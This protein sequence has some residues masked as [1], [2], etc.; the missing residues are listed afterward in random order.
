MIGHTLTL[1]DLKEIFLP[2]EVQFV[3][4]ISYMFQF[5]ESG[6]GLVYQPKVLVV[7]QKFKLARG[8]RGDVCGGVYGNSK[9][10]H[11]HH[12]KHQSPQT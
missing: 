2:L 9:H 8:V 10:H 12:H 6:E 7:N 5:P 11:K 4:V 1:G 3:S